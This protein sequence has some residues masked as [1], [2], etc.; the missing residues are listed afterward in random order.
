MMRT[1]IRTRMIIPTTIIH[2]IKGGRLEVRGEVYMVVVMVLAVIMGLIR[3]KRI[4][5]VRFV[6]DVSVCL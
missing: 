1:K 2:A 4:S 6:Q 5:I 3:M